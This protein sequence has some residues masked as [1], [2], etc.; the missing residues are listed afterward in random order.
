VV[1]A[2]ELYLEIIMIKSKGVFE[3]PKTIHI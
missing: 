1:G 2:K 3:S